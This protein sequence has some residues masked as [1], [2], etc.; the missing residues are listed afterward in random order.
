MTHMFDEAILCVNDN[1]DDILVLFLPIESLDFKAHVCE[2][3]LICINLFSIHL[4]IFGWYFFP[5]A[6]Y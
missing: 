6:Q 2:T 5:E 3:F 1:V 4:T